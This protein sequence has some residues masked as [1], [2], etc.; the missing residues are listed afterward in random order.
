[1]ERKPDDHTVLLT[2]STLTLQQVEEVAVQRQQ[3]RIDPVS[4]ARAVKAN[5]VVLSYLGRDEAVYGLNRGVGLNK[6]R[7]VSAGAMEDFNRN[8]IRSHC[9]G[10]GPDASEETVRAAMLIRLNAALNGHTGLSPEVLNRYAEFL[11]VG[12]HPVIPELGSVGEADIVLLSYIGLAMIGEGEVTYQGE[13][14]PA[15]EALQRTGMKPLQLG[16]KDGLGIVSSNAFS[17]A[18][19]ALALLESLDALDNCDLVFALSLE[20][21][22]GN[23]AP[24]DQR[25]VAT[26]PEEGYAASAS[27]IRGLITGSDLWDPEAVRPLQD[28]ISFRTAAH[29]HG[30]ARTAWESCW[31]KLRFHINHSD[32]N[33]VVL[34]D[35]GT[36]ISSAH[37]EIIH[38]I[39]PLESLAIALAHVAQSSVQRT[40]RFGNP[41]LTGLS[42]FLSQDDQS[43]IGFATLQKTA[44]SL[45][46]EIRLLAQPSSLDSAVLAGDMEDRAV[47]APLAV[48]K[49]ERLIELLRHVAAIEL[50]HAVQAIYL[51]GPVRLGDSTRQAYAFIRTIIEPLKRD[52]V[53]SEDIRLASEMIRDGSMLR[54]CAYSTREELSP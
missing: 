24:L 10:C 20:G 4:M 41:V 1:M 29:I 21:I 3:L 15:G 30:V 36:I 44:S 46:A 52:R 18:K 32:D 38:W 53:L 31:R 6:D 47:N 33:P 5:E 22:R 23:V 40:L 45:E 28:P 39:L 42:R 11:N 50:L 9:A 27:R 2:G 13:R 8:L 49:L 7:L 34:Q 19:A 35:E 26:R 48:R 51:R 12:I 16:P 37:F 14:L 17:A 43:M 25:I 54:S